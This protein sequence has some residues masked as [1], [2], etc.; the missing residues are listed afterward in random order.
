MRSELFSNLYSSTYGACT[1]IS[2]QWNHTSTGPVH[3]IYDA[4]YNLCAQWFL[5]P[6][7][8]ITIDTWMEELILAMHLL[9]E[10]WVLNMDN[11]YWEKFD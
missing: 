7:A 8:R 1:K 6:L 10:T 11:L 3:P 9:P 4:A 2:S 5:Q